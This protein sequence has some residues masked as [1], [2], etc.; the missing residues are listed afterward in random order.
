M[1]VGCVHVCV[2]AAG[3]PGTLLKYS[4]EREDGD[5]EWNVSCGDGIWSDE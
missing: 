5:L 1:Y 4:L 2:C 3:E